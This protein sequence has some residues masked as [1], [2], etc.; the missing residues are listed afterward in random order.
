MEKIQKPRWRPGHVVTIYGRVYRIKRWW[1]YKGCSSCAFN[2]GVK[3]IYPTH[4]HYQ[5][6]GCCYLVEIIHFGYPVLNPKFEV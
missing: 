2:N 4:K 5:A 3:C 1:F 6:P